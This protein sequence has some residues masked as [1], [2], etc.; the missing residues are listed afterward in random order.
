MIEITGVVITLIA[1]AMIVQYLVECSKKMFGSR[2][3]KLPQ[4]WS[5]G[6]SLALCFLFNIDLFDAFG[7]KTR[8]RWITV[9]FTAIAVSAGADPLHNLFSKLRELRD[10][11]DV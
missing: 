3:I 4:L 10:L 6:Y 8:F 11:E 9:I 7:W 1:T 2:G 5:L